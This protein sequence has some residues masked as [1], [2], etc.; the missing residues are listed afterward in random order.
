MTDFVLHVLRSTLVVELAGLHPFD[1]II[2]SHNHRQGTSTAWTRLDFA[3]L[4]IVRMVMGLRVLVATCQNNR[5]VVFPHT[6]RIRLFVVSVIAVQLLPGG[7]V[8]GH[9]YL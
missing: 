8:L 4:D 5:L 7:S 9:H 1:F 2:L 3:V 6:R